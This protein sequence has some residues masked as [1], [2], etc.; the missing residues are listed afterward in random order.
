MGATPLA[1]VASRHMRDHNEETKRNLD[2][3]IWLVKAIV[4]ASLVIWIWQLI[5]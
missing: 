4:V 2:A 3:I 1:L 5:T